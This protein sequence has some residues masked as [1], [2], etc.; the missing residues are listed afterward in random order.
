MSA[1]SSFLTRDRIAGITLKLHFGLLV[2]VA[3]GL[4][5]WAAAQPTTL[6]VVSSI[7][8]VLPLLLPLRGFLKRDRRTFAWATL[9]LVPYII[10]GLTEIVANPSGRDWAVGCL[11]LSFAAFVGCIAYLRVTRPVSPAPEPHD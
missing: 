4:I 8:L 7:L 3:V 1:N 6:R 9:C 5:R 11:L 10:V 2:V